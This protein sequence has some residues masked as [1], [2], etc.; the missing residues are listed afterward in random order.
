MSRASCIGVGR[1]GE[2]FHEM[3]NGSGGVVVQDLGLV[4]P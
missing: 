1:E 4:V 3:G 2:E